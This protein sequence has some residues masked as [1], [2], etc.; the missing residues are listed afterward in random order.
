MWVLAVVIHRSGP[1]WC[2]L[3]AVI[4]L[5]LAVAQRARQGCDVVPS[6][7]S[8]AAVHVLQPDQGPMG[9]PGKQ[10]GLQLPDPG[11]CQYNRCCDALISR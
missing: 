3:L 10:E 8:T 7:F 5:W 11:R 2:D 4:E 9:Q 6:C 1:A